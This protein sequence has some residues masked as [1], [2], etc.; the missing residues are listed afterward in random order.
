MRILVFPHAMELGGSQLNAIEIAGAV[1]D[2][3]HEVAIVSEAGPLLERVQGLGLP[4]HP[5]VARPGIRPS[6]RV[7]RQLRSLVADE[8]YDVVHGYEWPPAT[9]AAFGTGI[10]GTPYVCTIMSMSVAP[11]LPHSMPLI[12]GT[13][14]IAREAEAA[15]FC[16]VTILEPPIDVARNAPHAVQPLDVAALGVCPDALVIVSV[17]RLVAELKLEGLLSASDGTA[18]LNRAGTH[19]HLVIVG[20]GPARPEVARAADLANAQGGHRIV[21]L[22]GE[23]REP[24]PAYAAADVVI[25]MGGSA[26]RSLAFGKALIVQ[27]ERGFWQTATPETVAT[28]LEQGWFGLGRPGDG[29]VQGAVRFMAEVASLGQDRRRRELGRWGR[30]LAVERFSL[31][32]AGR[33]QERLYQRVLAS[34]PRARQAEILRATVQAMQHSQIRRVRSKFNAV[35]NDDFNAVDHLAATSAASGG[36]GSKPA[37]STKPDAIRRRQPR[38]TWRGA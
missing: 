6:W 9:E 26:I 37:A 13:A 34:R 15:G 4:H 11:F 27:G 24:R 23:W 12:V 17:S 32:A 38:Q 18:A 20:D 35:A 7:A 36:A 16:D 14:R 3:G 21:H 1:R 30:A 25:G 5:L 29:R 33:R 8:G 2:R 31:E 28:Y 22:L 10:A 19:V